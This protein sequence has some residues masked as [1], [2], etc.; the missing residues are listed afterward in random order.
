MTALDPSRFLVLSFD[1]Y[2]TLIDWEKGI[3]GALRDAG[4]LAGDA[5]PVET[6]AAL[7]DFAVLEADAERVLVGAPY[8]QI[9]ARVFDGLCARRGRT[10]PAGEGARFAASVGDW[11]PFADTVPALAALATRYRLA[12]LSN[13]DRASFARTAERLRAPFWRVC[14][15][16]EIGSYKPDVR[17]FR[18]LLDVVARDGIAPAQVLHV[19]QSLY[20]DHVPAKALGLATVHVDRRA[21][22]GG[23]AVVAPASPVVPDLRVTDLAQLVHSLGIDTRA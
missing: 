8:P 23:G 9:L 4:L 13:V 16:E 12:V 19:A 6:E 10:A 22:R 15:A 14:T 7:A 21:G 11:P 20:H 18:F 1:C 2:G 5:A 17:N 3:A